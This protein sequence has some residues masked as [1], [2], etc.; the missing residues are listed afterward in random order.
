LFKNLTIQQISFYIVLALAGVNLLVIFLVTGYEFVGENVLKITILFLLGVVVSSIVV[1]YLLERYVFS[2]IKLIYKFIH[3]S[4]VDKKD[5]KTL[6]FKDKSLETVNAEVIDWAQKTEDQLQSLKTLELYRKEYVGNVSHE[7]KTPIFSIQGYLHTLL[8]GGMFD[9]NIN[10][11][12]L[13]RAAQN[14]ERLKNIVEDLES[15]S[16]LESGELILDIEEFD[17]LS[18]VTDLLQDLQVIA[19][20]RRVKLM[21]KSKYETPYMVTADKSNIR[22]VLSNLIVNSIKYGK[23]GGVTTIGFFDMADNILVEVT[24]DGVGIAKD[25]LAHLF[26][27]FYRVDKSRSRNEGGS[28]LGLS[29]VKHII[30]AHNQ[31]INVRST[32][33][34][35]STFGFTL[36]KVK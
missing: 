6:S 14:T 5:K 7:L 8:D 16:R 19:D 32:E 25:D 31:T 10:V 18:L 20:E 9:E 29:I 23:E 21:L 12:F 24:D 4:K 34:V 26:D 36:K 28:G 35:G 33:G 30:E 22:Q 1:R 13:K 11:R 27:R 2:K 15:I 17:M 3:D